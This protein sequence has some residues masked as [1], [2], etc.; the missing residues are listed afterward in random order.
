MKSLITT[1]LGLFVASTAIA[2]NPA[3][4]HVGVSGEAGLRP[5]LGASATLV[6]DRYHLV[7]GVGYGATPLILSRF[8]ANVGGSALALDRPGGQLRVQPV[9]GVSRFAPGALIEALWFEG[10]ASTPA[11]RP[12]WFYTSQLRMEGA[13]TLTE[14]LSLTTHVTGGAAFNNNVA[15]GLLAVGVGLQL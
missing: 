6:S 12:E 13:V 9:V 1:L 8:S 14:T 11:A 2:G 3:A 15:V 10:D 5:T 7:A 4:L